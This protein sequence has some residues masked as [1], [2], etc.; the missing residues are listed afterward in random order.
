[1]TNNP[2]SKL[3]WK[4]EAYLMKN[5]LQWIASRKCGCGKRSDH[6]DELIY[7]AREFLEN[8]K[9]NEYWQEEFYSK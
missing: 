8:Y 5:V 2:N 9:D 6:A 1:M 3:D 7:F 4:D